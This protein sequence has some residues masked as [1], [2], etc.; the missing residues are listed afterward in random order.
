MSEVALAPRDALRDVNVG[1]SVSESSDLGRLGLHIRHA[2]QVVAELARAV[3]VGGGKLTYGGWLYPESFTALLMKE[4][5]AYGEGETRLTLCVAYPEHR[6]LELS[7]LT[8]IRNELFGL[9]HVLYLDAEGE[10]IEPHEGR[11]EAPEE[12]TDHETR[13]TSYSALRRTM[14]ARTDARVVVGGRLSGYE[15]VM[16][17]VI[18]EAITS[19]RAGQPLYVAGGFGGAAA[20]I[21]RALDVDPMDWLADGMPKHEQDEG[22]LNA[23]S[24]LNQEAL[25]AEWS[26]DDDGLD[27]QERRELSASHRPGE[28]ASLAAVGLSRQFPMGIADA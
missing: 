9:A 26:V 18:E 2:D 1:L 13:V 3:L 14:A 21:L 28:I 6:K 5:H 23:L 11:A 20:A 4:V 15:G 19:I 25:D 17:G 24:E 16:P 22:V 27:Q 7:E 10:P 12:V 8:R